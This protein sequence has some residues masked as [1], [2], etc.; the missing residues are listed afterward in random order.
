MSDRRT[1]HGVRGL[2]YRPLGGCHHHDRRTPH[3]VRG[4]KSMVN[5]EG[6]GYVF[7]SHPTRGAWIE[8]AGHPPKAAAQLSHPTRGAWIEMEPGIQT[9]PPIRSHPTRGA[10]I[11]MSYAGQA[12]WTSS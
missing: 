10:W 4:L 12:T 3:G 6:T 2:K 9:R 1:P 11:E 5:P 7:G 8:M